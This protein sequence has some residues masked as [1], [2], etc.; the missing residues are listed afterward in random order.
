MFRLHRRRPKAGATIFGAIAQLG[1]RLNGIQE[2]RGSTPL[3]STK[4]PQVLD[5]TVEIPQAGEQSPACRVVRP[6]WAHSCGCESRRKLV[7]ASEVKRN[8]GRV[9]ATDQSGRRETSTPRTARCGPACRVVWE[10]TVRHTDRPLCRSGF[11][12]DPDHTIHNPLCIDTTEDL[13]FPLAVMAGRDPAI[14]VGPQLS[15]WKHWRLRQP[16]GCSGQA[17]A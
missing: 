13:R 4:F 16:R 14:H 2:V 10:G 15:Y 7:T 9:T 11:H 5:R 6:A 17:G 1:E 12:I 3:G 8:C